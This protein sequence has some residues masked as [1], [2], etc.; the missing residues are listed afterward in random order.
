MKRKVIFCFV[1]MGL[2]LVA[3]I[4]FA[5]TKKLTSIGRYTFVRIRGVVPTQEVMK[6]LVELYAGDIKYGFDLA[7][8]GELYLPFME[9]LKTSKFEEKSLP[10]GDKLRWMLFR[11]QGKIKIV[12]DIEWAGKKP[13]DVFAFYVV[14]DWKKYEFIMPKPCGNISLRSIEEVPP[15]AAI[16]SL[17]VT[18]NRLNIKGNVVIDMS[19]SQNAKA[20]TVDVFGPDGAK[21]AT[22]KLTPTNAKVTMTLDKPGDYS[23]KAVAINLADKPSTNPCEAKVHVNFPPLCK[24]IT[25]CVTC[26]NYVGKPITFD[27]SESTDPDGQVV[28]V[29][30][31][32]L[33]KNGQVIDKFSSTSKPFTWTKTFLK[34]GNFTITAIA[35]DDFGAVSEPCRTSF[36]VTPKRSF[37]VAE[38]GPL[39]AKGSHGPYFFGRIGFLYRLIPDP[40]DLLISVGPGI[41]LKG[42]PWKSFVMGNVLLLYHSGPAY[43]GGGFGFATKSKEDHKGSF[44]LVGEIGIDVFNYYTSTGSL[45]FEARGAIGEDRSFSKNHKLAL[46]FRVIF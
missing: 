45:F 39:F 34:G 43:F 12:H 22:H 9:Q 21:I 2:L 18:P 37:F 38:G 35:T 26:L 4:S 1:I 41:A 44:E 13:L 36:E 40:L 8:F 11:S 28:R 42:E 24:L 23:F 29:D 27:A 14:K 17:V 33:D 3:N 19:G 30:F 32:L 7:G 31:E 6:R 16:C 10:I 20:M 5:Q 15:P 25:P 46:G